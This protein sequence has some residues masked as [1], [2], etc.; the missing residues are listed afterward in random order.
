MRLTPAAP[1]A[2]R[3]PRA[4]RVRKRMWVDL[5]SGVLQV[6]SEWSKCV[7]RW[8]QVLQ[9]GGF[10][11]RLQK[12][13]KGETVRDQQD[14]Y[15]EGR[16]EVGRSQLPGQEPRGVALVKRVQQIHRAPD[17][18]YPGEDYTGPTWQHEQCQ[19]RE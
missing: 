3:T 2:S 1:A 11:L 16:N 8:L 9:H 7:S 10:A 15:E 4:R 18:E 17:I 5:S 19:Q 12:N 13:A 14:R 6:P